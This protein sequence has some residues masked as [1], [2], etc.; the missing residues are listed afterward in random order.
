MKF[1]PDT[2]PREDLYWKSK[3]FAFPL[4]VGMSA[5]LID[6]DED[7]S[8]GDRSAVDAQ[9]DAIA[10]ATSPN[11]SSAQKPNPRPTQKPNFN[12][13]QKPN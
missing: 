5:I 12:S 11:L 2:G 10:A 8:D 13:T 1:D 7:L 6:A 3:E 4:S 9:N